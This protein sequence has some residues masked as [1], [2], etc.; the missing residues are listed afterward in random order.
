MFY[1]RINKVKIFDNKEGKKLLLFG[2]DLAQVK[3]M[4]FI[5]TDN[6]G[7]LPNFEELRLTNDPDRKRAIVAEA[8]ENIVSSRIL[9][10]IDNV[11]DNHQM[12]FGDTGYVLYQ[13]EEIPV[14]FDWLFIAYESDRNVR[15]TAAMVNDIVNA[16]SF[17]GFTRNIAMLAKTAANP[18]FAAT[19]EITKYIINIISNTAKANKDDLIGILYMSLNR[20]EHY[21]F[22]ERKKD[23]VPDLTNNMLIDYSIFAF[24]RM[25]QPMQP[26]NV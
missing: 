6:S 21:P 16:P 22:G 4:S 23:G 18:A 25:V 14:N 26:V 5:N 1:F 3:L 12:T 13:S 11:R 7:Y 20:Q 8:V 19:T 17:T 10:P 2:K 15:D 9:T 24:N